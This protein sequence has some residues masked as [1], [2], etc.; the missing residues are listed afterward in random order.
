MDIPIYKPWITKKEIQF[1][2]DAV[3]STWVSSIGKYID[4]FE[5]SF[6]NFIGSK[7]ALSLNNGTSACHL[8]LL[9]SGIKEG[10][11]VMVP[12][13]CFIAAVNAITYCGAKPVLIDIDKD[14]WNISLSEINKNFS[15]KTKAIFGVHMLGNPCDIEILNFCKQKNI[16]YIE[17][18]CESIG[19][20]SNLIKTGNIGH[21]SAF[22]FFGNKNLTTGEGGMITTN[23]EEVFNKVKC[24]KGQGQSK[25]YFHSEI[26]YN[27]RMTNIQA[28]LGYA[29]M[30]RINE[31]IEEKNR[32]YSTYKKLL[33]D[34]VSLQKVNENDIHSNWMFGF[35]CKSKEKVEIALNENGI[36]TRIMFYPINE[37]PPYKSD[38][39][40]SNSIFLNRNG[41]M[42]PSYP[43]LKNNQIEKICDLIKKNL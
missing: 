32:V 7:Y 5:D 23:S 25:R 20:S 30:L 9:C 17:D 40:Y 2:N 36:E 22:S 29:Q 34:H 18:A 15:T 35:V 42:L 43:Q 12:A 26:G 4:L 13:C 27:Y 8:A 33:Q 21:C 1:V 28:A 41:L 37:M 31:I 10:D 38:E 24:L 14:T 3:K 39:E 19:A 6:K 16:L 11:E